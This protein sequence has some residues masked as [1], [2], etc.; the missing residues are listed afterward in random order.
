MDDHYN[1]GRPDQTIRSSV[2]TK[3]VLYVRSMPNRVFIRFGQQKLCLVEIKIISDC[4]G[5]Q[6]LMQE[7]S[8]MAKP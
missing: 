5:M 6:H 1:K 7:K 2:T 4:S 8:L 3:L